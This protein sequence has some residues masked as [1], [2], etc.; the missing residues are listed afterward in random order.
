[1]NTPIPR[2]ALLLVL[3]SC[4]I[5]WFA[6]RAEEPKESNPAAESQEETTSAEPINK[7][8]RQ[9]GDKDYF[10]RQRAQ[11]ALAKLGFEA[12]DALSTATTNED[13]EIASRAKYL[14]RLMRVKWTEPGDSAAVKRCL[15]D[16]EY[17]NTN[18]R[19]ATM[20]ALAAL[21]NAEGV[22]ALGRL[23]RFE[24]SSL[25][26]KAAALALFAR[27]SAGKPPSAAAV[28]AVRKSLGNCKRPAARWLMTWSRLGA[29]PKAA[30]N[31][32]SKLVEEEQKKRCNRSRTTPTPK[33]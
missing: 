2:T 27:S 21:P 31:Q 9:L 4:S 20:R 3:V 12:F 6:A 30:M 5:S 25:M 26:S 28:K 19:E 14:L 24:K 15:R 1:M 17:Q 13:L 23:A 33:S 29:D 10:V 8:I 18:A 11:E 7:L 16:Y 22:A 32:W